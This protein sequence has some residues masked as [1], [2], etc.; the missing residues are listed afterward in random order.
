MC[1]GQFRTAFRTGFDSGAQEMQKKRGTAGV[2]LLTLTII[3]EAHLGLAEANGVFPGSDAIE[4]LEF[5]LLYILQMCNTNWLSVSKLGRTERS[6]QFWS[7]ILGLFSTGG[8]EARGYSHKGN[9]P[10]TATYLAREV[11]FN[12]LD[13][14]VL[15]T[16][17]HLARE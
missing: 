9:K 17:R 3:A 13:A 1:R 4:L 16:R 10:A 2:A 6:S 5:A 15:G 8:R 14:N 11:N 7:L 12:G